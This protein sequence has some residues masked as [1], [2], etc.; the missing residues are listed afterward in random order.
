MYINCIILIVYSLH[1]A[2]G[3]RFKGGKSSDVLLVGF[4]YRTQNCGPLDF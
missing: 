4:G 1:G 3:I 2:F